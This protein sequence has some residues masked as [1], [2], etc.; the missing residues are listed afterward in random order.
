[1]SKKAARTLINGLIHDGFRA[2]HLSERARAEVREAL[3]LI[4]ELI[5]R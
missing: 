2:D 1:M 3:L 5:K 4:L